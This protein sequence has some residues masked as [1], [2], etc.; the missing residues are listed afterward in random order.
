MIFDWEKRDS[1]KIFKRFFRIR[2]SK[3][4]KSIHL[5]NEVY[6]LYT[7]EPPTQEVS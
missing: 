3:N 5:E 7:N 6:F 4:W 2:L 1:K